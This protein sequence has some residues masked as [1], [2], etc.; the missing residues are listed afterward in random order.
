MSNYFSGEEQSQSS[1][2]NEKSIANKTILKKLSF[3]TI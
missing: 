3:I 1:K 2:L